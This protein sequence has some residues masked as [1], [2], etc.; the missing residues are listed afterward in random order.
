MAMLN[1]QRVDKS[2][3]SGELGEFTQTKA[4]GT[5]PK[6]EHTTSGCLPLTSLLIKCYKPI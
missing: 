4:L 6:N 3:V 5:H 1:N 2:A